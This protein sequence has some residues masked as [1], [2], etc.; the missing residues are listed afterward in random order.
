MEILTPILVLGIMGLVFG[1]LLGVAAKAFRVEKDERIEQVQE[2]LA[3]ANCGG[4]G[5]AGC[6]AFAEAVVTRGVNPA[7]CPS[8]KK[9]NMDKIAEVMG[10][11]VEEGEKLVAKVLCS[12]TCEKATNKYQYDGI[13][14]C[15]AVYRFGGGEKA[16]LYGCTGYGSCVRACPF[17]AIH[18]VDGVA[19]V[20]AEKCKG[21]GICVATCPK[22]IIE[23]IPAKQRT[24]VMCRSK[25]KGVVIKDICKAG[26]IGCKLCEKNCPKDAVHVL[27]NIAKIDYDKCVNCGICASKCPKQVIEYHKRGEA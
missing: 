16:C 25:E 17:D 13:T 15:V 14:D 27:D 5:Y 22:R 9:E 2:L 24:F 6:S 3:G 12:G 4:C 23:L 19:H 18:I 11:T 21:C 26:C 10:I 7:G 20:D 8:T 1:A